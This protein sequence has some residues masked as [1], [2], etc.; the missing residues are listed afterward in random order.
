MFGKTYFKWTEPWFFVLRER[1]GREWAIRL[2]F[3]LLVGVVL[4]C[5]VYFA[6]G[7][8]IDRALGVGTL[9]PFVILLILDAGYL[10]RDISIDEKKFFCHGNAGT[11]QHFT[12]IPL[13]KIAA[14]SIERD[15]ELGKKYHRMILL[16]MD[17]KY[18]QVGIPRRLSLENLAQKLFEIQI[19]VKLEGWAPRPAG[20]RT[21]T[22]SL[23][24]GNLADSSVGVRSVKTNATISPIESDEG[25][26]FNVSHQIIAALAAGWP[27][28]IGLAI[29]IGGIG[30]SVWNWK[31][32]PTWLSIVA[33]VVPFVVL[34]FTFQWVAWW[35]GP[36][37][38]A[39]LLRTARSRLAERKRSKI[40]YNDQRI[41][42]LSHNTEES[43]KKQLGMSFDDGFLIADQ[44]ARTI[45][46]EGNKFRWEIPFDSIIEAQVEEFS[47]GAETEQ[48][49]TMKKWYVHLAFQ[50]SEGR[51][52]YYL[53]L[54]HEKFGA[55][56]KA[57]QSRAEDL[58][59]Y[60]DGHV[61]A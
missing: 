29:V 60:L 17:N 42:A 35:A 19:P 46:F 50:T 49:V 32:N 59:L 12:E 28:L 40:A 16:T 26:L 1:S 5:I 36:I 30:W 54:A 2:G 6:G 14:A 10:M 43:C 9:V 39:Y 13:D 18:F 53:R 61:H 52:D 7:A 38:T 20:T 15:V 8:K 51:Q 34:F 24:G 45:Y 57:A 44:K 37:E 55:E 47:I 56:T 21:V 11:I 33:I 22:N 27:A 3:A 58:L 23:F 31:V 48:G 41:V 25:R 4:A